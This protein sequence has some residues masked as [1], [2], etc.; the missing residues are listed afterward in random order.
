MQETATTIRRG[1]ST[2][3]TIA[4]AKLSSTADVDRT[5]TISSLKNNAKL[6]VKSRKVTRFQIV[7]YLPQIWLT[8]SFNVLFSLIWQQ[9][10]VMGQLNKPITTLVPSIL[11]RN[12]KIVT[13][14]S[15]NL[16]QIVAKTNWRIFYFNSNSS[17]NKIQRIFFSFIFGNCNFFII[18]L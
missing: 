10:V 12:N 6:L 5:L 1:G 16:C 4:S 13:M 2:T 18:N 3:Q 11:T 15:I 14:N 8:H 7:A 9:N 17:L